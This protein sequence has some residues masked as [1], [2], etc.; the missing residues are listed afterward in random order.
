[1]SNMTNMNSTLS[2]FRRQL[3]EVYGAEQAPI[4]TGPPEMDVPGFVTYEAMVRGE[5]V[6]G[7]A[8]EDGAVVLF[9]RQNFGLVLDAVDFAG[10]PPGMAPREV[11]KR[12]VWAH[13]PR[14]ELAEHAATDELDLDADIA[15]PVQRQPTY[16]GGVKL[17]FAVRERLNG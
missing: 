14:H 9:L 2:A 1:M 5:P 4:K 16:D 17:V 10:E 8:R 7:W 13:G 6:R 15:I 11:V 3:K 12:L